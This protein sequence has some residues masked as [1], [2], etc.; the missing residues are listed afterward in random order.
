MALHKTKLEPE[1]VSLVTILE[2]VAKSLE[3]IQCIFLL[4]DSKEKRRY[5]LVA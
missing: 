5:H 2:N 3:S 4:G 1:P